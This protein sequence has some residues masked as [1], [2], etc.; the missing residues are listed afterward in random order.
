MLQTIA[1]GAPSIELQRALKGQ[2]S[3]NVELSTD[4]T[5]P[6][7]LLLDLDETIILNNGALAAAAKEVTSRSLQDAEI[8]QIKDSSIIPIY[9]L[10]AT[11]YMH[12]MVPNRIVTNLMASEADEASIVI[13]TA[14]AENLRDHT[15]TFL[16]RH[17]VTFDILIM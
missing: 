1:I 14:R 15:V 17:S 12:L 6:K 8:R 5:V 16:R 13:L 3:R 10:A 4:R 2:A 7:I 9:H 11:K